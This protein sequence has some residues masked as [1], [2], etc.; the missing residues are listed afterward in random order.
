MWT[1]LALAA[2]TSGLLRVNK[3]IK[4]EYSNANEKCYQMMMDKPRLLQLRMTRASIRDNLAEYGTWFPSSKAAYVRST[5]QGS[6][7]SLYTRQARIAVTGLVLLLVVCLGSV[8]GFFSYHSPGQVGESG[9]ESHALQGDQP[10]ALVRHSELLARLWQGESPN[11]WAD[12]DPSANGDGSFCPPTRFGACAPL[13]SA[14]TTDLIS[15]SA[16]VA[17]AAFPPQP[18]APPAALAS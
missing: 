13:V 17:H 18:R 2:W 3:G 16:I 11:P 9:P 15:R 6:H 7:H 1:L 10:F 5:P 12:E 14:Q 8:G 4:S